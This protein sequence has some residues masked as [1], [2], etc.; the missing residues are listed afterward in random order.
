MSHNRATRS[1]PIGPDYPCDVELHDFIYHHLLRARNSMQ[2]RLF[3]PDVSNKTIGREASQN[4][5]ASFPE[6]WRPDLP[7]YSLWDYERIYSRTGVKVCGPTEVRS[8]W[9]YNDLKPRVY[10][11]RGP[12]QH[13]S[14]KYI[15]EVMNIFVDALPM[16]HR[17]Q[18]FHL[19]SVQGDRGDTAFIYDYTS[20][21]SS[22]EEIKNFT[23]VLGDFCK[24]IEIQLVDTYLGVIPYDLGDLILE[25]NSACNDFPRFDARSILDMSLEE[26]F[27]IRH[28]CGMLGVPGN[29]SSCTLCHG[30]HLAIILSS[31]TKGKAIGDDAVGWRAFP[32]KGDGGLFEL[33]RNLGR[34]SRPKMN[35]WKPDGDPRLEDE[36]W[37]YVKR[38]IDRYETRLIQGTQAVWPAIPDILNLTDTMHTTSN[39]RLS[40]H[41]RFKKVANSLLSFILQLSRYTIEDFEARFIDRYLRTM[42]K[43]SGIEKYEDETGLKFVY[44]RYY[45]GGRPMDEMKSQLWTVSVTVP[46][47]QRDM[48]WEEPVYDRAF[49]FGGCKSISLLVGLDYAVTTPRMKKIV[50]CWDEEYFERYLSKDLD[51]V[52]DV[53][54]RPYCPSWMFALVRLHYD[55]SIFG[56][57]SSSMIGT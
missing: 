3:Y 50:P 22:L 47:D 53:F 28:T 36:T 23:R 31:V 1:L 13:H 35:L 43:R 49:V 52:Y 33:L 32:N 24:G 34:I 26:D 16:T 46:V 15:Q 9:K 45:H 37:H 57:S 12:D 7:E 44:P 27:P 29:I 40:E 17:F 48:P 18:R 8:A 54:I 21:T 30:I 10:Y 11:A 2:G 6:I 55:N 4:I 42:V 25:Y 38:P 19:S 39:S 51:P 20:F 5:R 14:S 56:S 41:N